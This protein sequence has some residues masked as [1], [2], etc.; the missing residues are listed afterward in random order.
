MQRLYVILAAGCSVLISGTARANLISN[1]SFETPVVTTGSFDIFATGSTGITGWTVTGP[2]GKEVA[3]VSTAFSQNGVLFNAEDGN[4]WLDLT[5]LS[6]NS[7]EGLTQTVTTTPGTRYALTF[8][9][10]NTTGGG[11][12]GTASS[13]IVKVNGAAAG[14]FT[15]SNAAPASLNW[16]QFTETFTAAGT[17]TA[18]EFDNDDPA[19]DNS[20]GLDNVDLEVAPTAVPEPSPATAA[21][22]GLL[23]LL[24]AA[25]FRARR[26]RRDSTAGLSL[27]PAPASPSIGAGN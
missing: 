5:G 10:G 9:V 4:Q 12:F 14:T 13:V 23:A 8:F 18:I 24:A 22:S 6:A 20:N 3:V 27:K 26:S 15:N 2:P 19:S 16:Q 25:G 7:T 21:L 1:G 17:S 11:I